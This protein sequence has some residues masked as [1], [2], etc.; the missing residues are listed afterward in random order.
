M[1]KE[2]K[3]AAI[4]LAAILVFLIGVGLGATKGIVI[5]IN[6][7][8]ANTGVVAPTNPPATN[9]PATNP[10]ATNPPATNPPASNPAGDA[11]TAPSADATTA[12]AADATTAAPASNGLP[13]TPDEIAA[14]YNEVV[15]AAKK[16]QNVTIHKVGSVKLTCTDCSVSFAKSIVNTALN[17]L[18]QDTD[19]TRQ[20]VNGVQTDGDSTPS[21]VLYPNGRDVTLTGAD[22][23]NATAAPEGDGYKLTLTIKAETSSFDGTNTVNPESHN[24]AM[25][26]LN[27]AAIEL[28]IDGASITAA[29]MSYPGATLE[30]WVNGAGK[31]T[32]LHILLPMSGNGTGGI[33]NISLSVGI[34]GQMDDT[35]ELTY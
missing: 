35:W 2:L 27:L 16:E 26:P 1:K 18:M 34:E 28:P 22:L 4:V 32:K 23:A 17:A 21:Q 15:N 13:S 19:W 6:V 9:P 11:T 14:K 7:N 33:K 30:A 12:P 3:I 24:K 20:Y 31:L 25:D 10:P 8:G 29:D 5:D